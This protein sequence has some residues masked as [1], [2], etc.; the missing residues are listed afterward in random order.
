MTTQEFFNKQTDEGKLLFETLDTL[1]RKHDKTVTT[2]VGSIMSVKE[3]LVYKQENVFKYGLT[4]T[5]NHFSYHSMVMYA[6]PDVLEKFKKESK[7]IKFQKGCFNFKNIE[8][9]DLTG[10]E[11]FLKLSAQ[12]DFGPVINHYK[13]K[14]K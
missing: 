9:I 8:T 11:A 7:G 13:Q 1:I 5:K 6:N 2:E 4:I 3:A 14:K 12:K 10:F